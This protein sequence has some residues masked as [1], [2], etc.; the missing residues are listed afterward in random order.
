MMPDR[1]DE[2]R[3]RLL[4][5]DQAQ[6]KPQMGE[7]TQLNEDLIEQVIPDEYIAPPQEEVQA[8]VSR[9]PAMSAPESRRASLATEDANRNLANLITAAGSSLTGF[10]GG[11]AAEQSSRFSKG[12]EYLKNIGTLEAAR[13]KGLKEIKNE[14]GNPEFIAEANAVGMEPYHQVKTLG[15]GS[16]GAANSFKL[17]TLYNPN[18]RS[19]KSIKHNSR[20]GGILDLSDNIFIPEEGSIVQ[21]V[22]NKLIKTEDVGGTV[23]VAPYNQYDKNQTPPVV[24]KP[25]LGPK[26][27]VGTKGQGEAIEKGIAEG[28]KEYQAFSGSIKDI[29]SASRTIK[30]GNNVR[31]M[32]AAIYSLVRSVEPK[33]VL[34]EQ[35][36]QVISGS[37]YMPTL[38]EIEDFLGKKFTGN[39]EEMRSSF[40][41]LADDIKNRLEQRMESIPS[42]FAP[43]SKQA[44]DAIRSVIPQ[45]KIKEGVRVKKAKLIQIE[46]QAKKFF[47]NDKNAYNGFLNKKKQEL[48]L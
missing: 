16:N 39:L 46:T 28:Q 40:G 42:R 29:E 26:Y 13:L 47:G 31:A 44:Q 7:Q 20:T 14:D 17:A 30:N 33:G 41:G 48:G 27:G 35:D 34:T 2:L 37:S 18:D 8:Q 24:T 22:A 23:T 6:I 43:E 9:A 25:G 38:Q 15:S 21:P 32:S 5:S 4:L 11:T 3:K 36:F 1:Y 19:Y 12:N 10:M 45:D